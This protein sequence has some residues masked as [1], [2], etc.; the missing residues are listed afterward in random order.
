M[1]GRSARSSSRPSISSRSRPTAR[2]GYA[3]LFGEVDL[4]QDVVMPGAFR[5][6]LRLRGVRGVKLLFQHDPNEPIGVWLELG[7]DMKGLYARGRLMPEVTKAREVLSLMRAGALDWLSIGFRTVQGRTDPA[8]GVRRLDKIDL[9]HLRTDCRCRRRRGSPVKLRRA[10]RD[11]AHRIGGDAR[12]AAVPAAQLRCAPANQEAMVSSD[13][14]RASRQLRRVG[15]LLHAHNGDRPDASPCGQSEFRS[16]P[17]RWP[18]VPT[19]PMDGRRR[20]YDQRQWQRY[21]YRRART[22]SSGGGSGYIRLSDQGFCPSNTGV[23]SAEL[24]VL[25]ASRLLS[26]VRELDPKWSPRP[27]L[28]DTVEGEIEAAV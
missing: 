15:W 3:S 13:A 11:F 5:E 2:S 14:G 22:K 6:S 12:L 28:T 10:E 26:Q 4:G 18:A 16:Q 23:R 27:S 19:A 9:W 7:E 20:R 21:T 1:T 25:Q 17:L 24:A 8:S